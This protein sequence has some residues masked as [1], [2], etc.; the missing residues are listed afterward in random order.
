MKASPCPAPVILLLLA[1]ITAATNTP[2]KVTA[3]TTPDTD[4]AT[5]RPLN[6]LRVGEPTEQQVVK[7]RAVRVDKTWWLITCNCSEYHCMNAASELN[8]T[9]TEVLYIGYNLRLLSNKDNVPYYMI[10]S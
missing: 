5:T 2:S 3:T 6:S 1:T 10:P 9:C 7:Y 4:R 8:K